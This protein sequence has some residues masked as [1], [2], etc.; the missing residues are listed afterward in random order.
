[1]TYHSYTIEQVGEAIRTSFSWRETVFKLG[2]NGD[3]GSNNQTFKRIAN[4]N[5]FDYSHFKGAGWSKGKPAFNLIPLEELLVKGKIVKSLPLKRRL[6]KEGLL[7][8]RCC[9]CGLGPEW[10]GIR[11]ELQL[12]H[13]DGDRLNNLLE[14]LRIIC[15]NCHTQTPT[16]CRKK[17]QIKIKRYCKCCQQKIIKK[18]LSGLCSSCFNKQRNY[19][20]MRK[21]ERPGKEVLL[22]QVKELG[23]TGTG[24]LYGVS[25]T[26]IRKWLK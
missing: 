10:N 23:Y 2:L 4:E 22:Q 7:E 5:N 14:N 12:D 8:E 11:L 25:D 6:I 17:D 16:Y 3:G 15:P 9:N 1:M 18:N 20:L 24:R 13:E 21:V 19:S 26:S